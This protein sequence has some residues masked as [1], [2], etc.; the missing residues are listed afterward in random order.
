VNRR[1]R[2]CSAD[3]FCSAEISE[4]NE[5]AEKI[6]LRLRRGPCRTAWR[7]RTKPRSGAKS[8]APR[9]TGKKRIS[10]ISIVSA[11]SALKKQN[12]N[13]MPDRAR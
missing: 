2:C 9:L 4:T 3:R 10:A 12:P 6:A 11:I 8:H 7:H 13:H 5:T 1:R